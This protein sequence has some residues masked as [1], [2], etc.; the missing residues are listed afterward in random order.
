[1]DEEPSDGFS[2]ARGTVGVPACFWP[3]AASA[4]MRAATLVAARANL[5]LLRNNI[6]IC[7]R[8]GKSSLSAA[9]IGVSP[10]PSARQQTVQVFGRETCAITRSVSRHRIGTELDKQTSGIDATILYSLH[11]DLYSNIHTHNCVNGKPCEGAT[12]ASKTCA[13]SRLLPDT[14]QPVTAMEA[15]ASTPHFCIA[16]QWSE[17]HPLLML[18]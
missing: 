10:T 4:A 2:E 5:G 8:T 7:S 12:L 15:S 18:L 16:S 1:M 14:S 3:S 17:Y 11:I 13:C 9:L 6:N